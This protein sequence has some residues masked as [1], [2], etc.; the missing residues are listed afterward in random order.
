MTLSPTMRNFLWFIAVVSGLVAGKQLVES[1]AVSPID[2]LHR[3]DFIQEYVF[4]RAVVA[5]ENPYLPIPEMVVRWFDPAPDGSKI[6]AHP[7]P[8]T[9]V[10]AVLSAPF[11]LLDYPSAALAWLLFEL[12]LLAIAW[13]TLIRWWG[14]DVP[15]STR[16]LL[17]LLSLSLGP[18]IQELYF[19]NLSLILLALLL[20]AWLSLRKNSDWVGGAWLGLAIAIKLTGWPIVLWLMAKMRWRAVVAA[21]LVV[22]GLHLVAVAVIGMDHVIDYYRRIGPSIA[23]EYRQHDGNY[24]LWTIGPRLFLPFHSVFNNFVAD[25]PFDNRSLAE[26]LSK[27]APLIGVA[28]GLAVAWR[29]RE[30]DS[31]FGILVCLSL[32]VN[33]VAWDHSLLMIS[34]PIAIVLKRLSLQNWPRWETTV[35]VIA[36]A[37]AMFPQKAYLSAAA[38]LFATPNESGIRM[39]PFFPALITYV[40][41]T[42]LIAWIV[43]L[44]RT[45][46]NPKEEMRSRL[47]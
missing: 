42:S 12:V 40:P 10:T 29:C 17:Y 3:K 35:A 8:H 16:I 18:L 1:F 28:L 37:L 13:E 5:G 31:S 44:K 34:I 2:E 30:F 26:T 43:L 27:V 47:G 39:M 15:W 21:G 45:E 4:A 20:P 41:L 23:R 11:A 46:G 9:P 14:G 6:W 7:A 36:F 32:P 19:G 22:V 33:P 38:R 25:V 24:S